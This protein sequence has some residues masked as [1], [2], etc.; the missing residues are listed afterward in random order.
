MI[1]SC[2]RAMIKHVED[3][4]VENFEQ[5]WNR[6][7][8]RYVYFEYKG[9]DWDSM[10]NVYRPKVH[11]DLSNDSLFRVMSDMLYPLRDGHTN[12]ITGF[13]VSRNWSWYLDRPQNFDFETLERNYLGENYRITGPFINTVFDSVGY[14]KYGSFSSLFSE[15]QLDGLLEAFSSYKGLIIDVRDNGGGLVYNAKTLASRF[16]NE[17]KIMAYIK[18]KNGVGKDNYTKDKA[19]YIQPYDEEEYFSKPVVILT[20]R[21]CYSATS[22]FATYMSSLDHVTII[23]DTTGGGGGLPITYQLPNSW[24]IRY[25]STVTMDING[26]NIE[27]GVPCDIQVNQ[28]ALDIANGIDPILEAGILYVLNQ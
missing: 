5:L 12:L 25:S 14:M 3:D 1:I 10:Y 23:G 27:D 22:L 2:E 18:S 11:E 13:D 7:N 17:E 15:D 24:K 4:P 6:M 21:S 26:F 16:I 20:N 9:V 8:E 19:V 28:T